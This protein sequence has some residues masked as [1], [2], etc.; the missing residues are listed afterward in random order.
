LLLGGDV[1]IVPARGLY[2]YVESGSGYSSNDIPADLYYAALD[3][4]WND[5]GDDR[6]GEPG[7]DDLLPEIGV[8]RMPFGNVAELDNMLNK[9]LMY[10]DQPVL[11]ELENPLFAGENL[12]S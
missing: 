5:D 9:I 8:A 4:T 11:G 3:G 10:Q 7:E 6:W 2:C 1:D 12:Y